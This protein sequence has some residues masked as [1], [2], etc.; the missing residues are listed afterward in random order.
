M[1]ACSARVLLIDDNRSGLAARRMVLE[2][3][4]YETIGSQ[5]PKDALNL[6]TEAIE[7]GFPF[8]LIVT[9]FKMP[10][11]NGIELI[12]RLRRL[13]ASVPVILISGFVDALGLT[14]RST[15]ANAV[16]MKSANEVQH[17]IRA[18][19]RL[20]GGRVKR[21]PP[22]RAAASRARRTGTKA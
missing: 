10:D 1:A 11:L 7:N 21:K 9:D 18:A 20:L 2:E 13:N 15:G 3:L 12:E 22:V 17:L 19:N 4:G 16:I 8:D 6:F 14:E 5:N